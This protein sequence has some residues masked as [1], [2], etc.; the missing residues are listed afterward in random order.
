MAGND[1]LMRL[2]VE[3]LVDKNYLAGDENDEI[4][5]GKPRTVKLGL[6]SNF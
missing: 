6:S 5:I 2:N 1:L 3:S 4:N